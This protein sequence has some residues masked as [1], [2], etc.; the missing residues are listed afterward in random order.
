M[1]VFHFLKDIHHCATEA[2]V[3]AYIFLWQGT[4]FDSV[5]GRIR[6]VWN[7]LNNEFLKPCFY[8]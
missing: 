2:E 6:H 4:K 7:D 1:T 3:Q 8:H 5:L